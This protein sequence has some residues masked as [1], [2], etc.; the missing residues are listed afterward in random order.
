MTKGRFGKDALWLLAG[1]V[2]DEDQHS[3]NAFNTE[4]AEAGYKVVLTAA[5][6]YSVTIHSTDIIRTRITLW[7]I[8]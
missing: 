7:L 6:G 2:D 4:L 5:D 1:F 8:C 3:D